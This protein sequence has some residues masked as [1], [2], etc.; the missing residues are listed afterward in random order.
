MRDNR[1]V[2]AMKRDDIDSSCPIPV[3]RHRS[4]TDSTTNDA[5]DVMR[6][7]NI[8]EYT[9]SYRRDESK[10]R[11]RVKRHF[12]LDVRLFDESEQRRFDY[13]YNF[14]L[15]PNVPEDV[16]ARNR[17][18][19]RSYSIFSRHASLFLEIEK[20]RGRYSF[21]G[22]CYDALKDVVNTLTHRLNCRMSGMILLLNDEFD[23]YRSLHPAF[24]NFV[25]RRNV[26]VTR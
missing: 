25:V 12:R 3:K 10:K 26:R 2:D 4:G 23:K 21:A 19:V 20:N 11:R 5:I 24:F 14:S 15:R 8:A 9:Q 13:L 6:C 22:K 17:A 18:I 1:R 16:R 7:I